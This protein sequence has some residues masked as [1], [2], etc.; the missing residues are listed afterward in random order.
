MEKVIAFVRVLLVLA[1]II[2][3]LVMMT[4]FWAGDYLPR[5]AAKKF[6]PP[7]QGLSYSQRVLYA[8][9]V[10]ASEQSL[11]TPVDA[12]A[13][14]VPF[15]VSLGESVDSISLRLEEEGLITSAETF[16]TF[17]IYA[18]LDRGVQAGRYSLSAAMT[19]VQIARNL[20][21]AV[22]EDVEFNILAGWR[23]EEIAAALPTSGINVSPL[24]FLQVVRNPPVEIL[25]PGLEDLATLEGFLMPG[26]YT[27]RRETSAQALAE[28]FVRRFDETIPEDV[29]AAYAERG[30]SLVE[31][32][33]LASM[34]Q[35][36]AMVTDEQPMIASAFY[37]RLAI[38][39]K[40]DSDPTAQF[41]LGYQ[42][43]QES[44]W[45]NPLSRDDL[46]V[47]SRY[48]TYVYPGLPPGPI[49]SPS[50]DALNAVAYPAQTGY[51]YFR[52]KCDGSS[53][54]AFAVTYEEHLQNACP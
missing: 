32:V 24:D 30:L 5:T 29:R 25:P 20:Q 44:W 39:M 17:L 1:V 21:D 26:S 54:H 50:L 7:G 9:R 42:P 52:A 35:R 37:N 23:A 36:E 38:D 49:C 3:C 13:E 43:S 22:P 10:L 6:G 11:L 33:T 45:K 47:N 48:N 31:A 28:T 8:T 14:T 15:Q 4:L 40:L 19:P 41:A 27:I 2:A 16:R 46:Q 18:G 51:Y 12:Q 34:V 53:R